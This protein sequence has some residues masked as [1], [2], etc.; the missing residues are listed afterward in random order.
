MTSIRKQVFEY[1][2]IHPNKNLK[3]VKEHFKDRPKN[4]IREYYRQSKD[5]SNNMSKLDIKTEL[6]KIVKDKKEP[7][8]TKVSAMRFY[9]ELIETTPE[10]GEDPLLKLLLTL[11][12]ENSD[13]QK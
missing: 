11:E 6:I 3:E 12:K 4:T 2:N 1:V 8:S 10:T 9:K 5:M 7:G 13:S